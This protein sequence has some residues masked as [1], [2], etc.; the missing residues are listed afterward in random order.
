MDSVQTKH[1]DK[2]V[3]EQRE[4]HNIKTLIDKVQITNNF[5][6]QNEKYVMIYT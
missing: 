2:N 3:I 1:R 4:D 6:R 5:V